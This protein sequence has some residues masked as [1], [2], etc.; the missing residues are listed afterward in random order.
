MKTIRLQK[1]LANAGIA[2]RRKCEEIITAGRV[3]VNQKTVTELGTKVTAGQDIISLDGKIIKPK[4][5]KLTYIMLHKPEGVISSASDPHKRPV[6]TDFVKDLT[7]LRL[8]PVGRLDYDS[9]GLILLTNDGQLAQKLTHPRHA[10]P[11]TYTVSLRGIP[12]K[13]GLKAFREGL[14]I[15]GDSAITA[16]A[17]IKIL[18]KKPPGCTAS[19]TIREGRNRQIRKMCEAIGC[20]VLRLKRV[21]M[22]SL[23]LGNLSRGKYRNLTKAELNRLLAEVGL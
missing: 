16:P 9:S 20:P 13:E 3:S 11:K 19:V 17:Q 10:I 23:K 1:Y 8:F 2:S 22:A 18:D 4:P 6:V 12:T 15:D 5:Q 21:A 14:F 7:Q